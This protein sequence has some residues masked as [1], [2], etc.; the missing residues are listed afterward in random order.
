MHSGT[1]AAIVRIVSD[2]NDTP[3]LIVGLKSKRKKKNS[4][5]GVILHVILVDTI[6][7]GKRLPGCPTFCTKSIK[8]PHDLFRCVKFVL[9]V[10]WNQV[11]I[12]C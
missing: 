9:C 4:L 7:P 6:L 2:R 12:D 11:E 8:L 3:R 1:A 5:L 10:N